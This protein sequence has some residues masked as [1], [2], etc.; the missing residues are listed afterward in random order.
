MQY[1]KQL[2]SEEEI[3]IFMAT[4]NLQLQKYADTRLSLADGRIVR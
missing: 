3:A 2:S 1:L 4:H